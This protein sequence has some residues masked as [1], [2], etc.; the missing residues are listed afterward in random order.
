MDARDL[1]YGLPP[2]LIAE[3]ARV[4]LDTARRWKRAGCV[5]PW[6]RALIELG[7]DGELGLIAPAWRGFA[8]K[9]DRLWTP[10]GFAVRPGELAAIPYRAALLAALEREL[11][12]PQQRSLFG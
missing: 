5:P 11:A 9:A 3:L 7:R 6:G 4:S 10:H 1:L 12:E 2:R 8:L